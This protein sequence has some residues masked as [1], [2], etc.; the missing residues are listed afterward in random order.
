VAQ[1]LSESGASRTISVGSHRYFAKDGVGLH[2]GTEAIT[3]SK[4]VTLDN[5]RHQPKSLSQRE[6]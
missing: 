5:P 1:C 2:F 4:G 3:K 6:K